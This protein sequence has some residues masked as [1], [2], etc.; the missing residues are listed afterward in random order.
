MADMHT[1]QKRHARQETLQLRS[2]KADNRR[3]RVAQARSVERP[4]EDQNL[5]ASVFRAAPIGI[6]VVRDRVMIE[7]N[8]R[9]CEMT[10]YEADEL[11][12]HRS[13]MLYPTQEDYDYVGRV[14]YDQIARKGTGAVETRLQRKD[15]TIMD[16]LVSSTPLDSANLAKGVTFTVMDITEHKRALREKD[17]IAR[18]PSEN[19]YPVFRV[20]AD[21]VV[22]SANPASEPLLAERETRVGAPA[23]TDWAALVHEV[24]DSGRIGEMDVVHR[25]RTLVIR[26]VPIPEVGYVNF[27]ATD[28]TDHR[29]AEEDLLMQRLHEK[30]RVEAELEKTRDALV[31]KT[32]LAAIG[33]MS[34]SIA[35]DLRNP[36][37]AVRNAAY[38]LKRWLP[39][40]DPR[41]LEHVGIIEHEVTRADRII[42]NLLN[43]T[44]S[45]SPN[46]EAVDF[47]RLVRRVLGGT[48]GADT[49]QCHISLSE[50]P[51]IVEADMGQLSQVLA[52]L[53]DN[54]VE[55]MD[56]RGD[57]FIEATRRA[58]CDILIFRDTG[59]GWSEDVRGRLFEPLVTTKT[60]GT[61][62]GLAICRQIVESHNGTIEAID[63]DKPGAAIRVNLP[64]RAEV[65]SN[66]P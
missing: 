63:T 10:G 24:L 6:G 7:V 26:A 38:L 43:L 60:T 22:L 35:H 29:R 51:F 44:R 11:I 59:P 62:L 19:P 31:R 53:L 48:R 14:K 30:Q 39:R 52:N 27:Y 2:I 28:V 45:R 33:Q 54:A 61:G 23:P 17:S 1:P 57:M 56:E 50:E 8:D 42:A 25:G 46:K 40:E 20:A 55:A 47:G 32:R 66:A 9:M 41:L 5:I 64:R 3:S 58:D 15:G 13:R 37:G 16:A 18:F 49:V 36:L 4:S 21:G 12:G 65:I 34:A